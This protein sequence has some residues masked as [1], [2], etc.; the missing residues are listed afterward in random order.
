MEKIKITVL[1]FAFIVFLT[2]CEKRTD[3]PDYETTDEKEINVEEA[4]KEMDEFINTYT[5]F[6]V[7]AEESDYVL[8]DITGDG[9]EELCTTVLVGSGMVHSDLIVYDPY[10]HTGYR[11]S[12]Y[13]Y[14]YEIECIDDNS[15]VVKKIE[16]Y[17]KSNDSKP[18]EISGTLVFENDEIVFVSTECDG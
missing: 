15:I 11:L 2:G 16:S 3:Y 10:M 1:C 6:Q 13:L 14:S 8:C 5:G 12:E 17:P 9:Y 4:K 18:E 7:Y